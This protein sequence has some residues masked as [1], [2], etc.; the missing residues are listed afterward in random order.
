V[1]YKT[2]GAGPSQAR[3]YAAILDLK[4]TYST[5]GNGII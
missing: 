3:E 2:P 5:K 1:D 4:F